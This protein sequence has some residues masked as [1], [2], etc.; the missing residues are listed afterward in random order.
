MV[1]AA[2]ELIGGYAVVAMTP[3]RLVGMRDPLGIRPLVLG[4]LEGGHMLASE[5]A[6]ITSIGAEPVREVEPGELVIIDRN[7]V[8]SRRLFDRDRRVSA[9]LSTSTWPRQRDRRPQRTSDP[10]EIGRPG[11]ERLLCRRRH[12]HP[13]S[14]V[15]ARWGTRKRPASLTRWVLETTRRRTF[16][17]PTRHGSSSLAGN[18]I[19]SAPGE[20]KGAVFLMTPCPR[21]HDDNGIRM[22]Q[23]AP[24]KRTWWWRLLLHPPVPYGIDAHAGRTDRFT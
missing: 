14:S 3:D 24:R 9:S 5:T 16:I 6:A 23:R 2:K 1:D 7:G 4:R 10:K 12:P 11:P 17:Q 8:R 19:R 22:L 20:G 13:D 18:C 15:S 21:Y